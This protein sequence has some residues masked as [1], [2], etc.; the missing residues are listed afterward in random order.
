MRICWFTS[1]RDRDA[2]TLFRDVIEALDR[3]VIEGS[4]PVVFLNRDLREAEPSDL[5][6]AYAAERSIPVVTLSTR[7][8]LK[9][10]NLR[11]SAG[12][13]LFDAEVYSRIRG[14]DFDLI[15]LA[16]YMLVLSPVLFDAFPVLNIHPSLPGAY[17]GAWE[18]VINRTIDDGARTFGAMVHMVEA[19]L[20]E[21]APVAYVRVTPEGP[22]IDD[23]YRRAQSGEA[24]AR[25]R[26]FE[27]VRQREFEVEAPLIVQTLS[28]L[29]R[30]A[31]EIRGRRVFF[32]GKAAPG[33]VD[34]TAEVQR[35]I[36]TRT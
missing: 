30:G 35:W 17:K 26:L 21:G 6:I 7:R 29:S 19:V 28:L 8:F 15:F 11:L 23:L 1:G 2:Y 14:F 3:G 4:I 13:G 27:M 36:A 31:L 20:D 16:G 18:E 24:E 9:E 5:I 10:R 32:Q 22:L 34:I 12:R 25:V 33:G